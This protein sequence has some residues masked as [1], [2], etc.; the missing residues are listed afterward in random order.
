MQGGKSPLDHLPSQSSHCHGCAKWHKIPCS[1]V[2]NL[3]QGH[4]GE[5]LCS[6]LPCH[7]LSLR[8]SGRTQ[9]LSIS[10]MVFLIFMLSFLLSGAGLYNDNQKAMDKQDPDLGS[11][12]LLLSLQPAWDLEDIAHAS[13]QG[14]ETAKTNLF[15]QPALPQ[16]CPA[17]ST[18]CS[19]AAPT[20]YPLFFAALLLICS[21]TQNLLSFFRLA[22]GLQTPTATSEVGT[23]QTLH[24]S[25][26]CSYVKPALINLCL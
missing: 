16:H 8:G 20:T 4:R 9:L 15:L 25:L 7:L 14:H 23:R 5:R 24:L 18:T 21:P 10:L 17:P 13:W 22:E 26:N 2:N 19:R 1:R 6:R 12:V 11:V 3:Q